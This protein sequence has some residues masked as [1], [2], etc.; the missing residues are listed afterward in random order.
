MY[1]LIF[2][3]FDLVIISLIFVLC[4]LFI[5]DGFLCFDFWNFCV[6]IV[7]EIVVVGVVNFG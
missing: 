3:D 6:I 2:E 5:D 7:V 1:I 4:D